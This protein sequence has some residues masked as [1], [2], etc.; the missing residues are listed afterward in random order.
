MYTTLYS[1]DPKIFHTK[2]KNCIHLLCSSL[3]YKNIP[4]NT[5]NTLILKK[6]HKITLNIDKLHIIYLYCLTL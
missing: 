1:F 4:E 3:Y 5:N 6:V 2:L